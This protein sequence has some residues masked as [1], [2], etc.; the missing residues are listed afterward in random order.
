MISM[1]TIIA[2]ASVI[3]VVLCLAVVMLF[4]FGMSWS[5]L[6]ALGLPGLSERQFRWWE[7]TGLQI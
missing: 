1:G 7:I 3:G 6:F 2:I 5:F 4:G